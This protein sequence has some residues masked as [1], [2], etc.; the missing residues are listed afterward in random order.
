M[1][2]LSVG[3]LIF[4]SAIAGLG[5]LGLATGHFAGVWQPV[6]A[7]LPA[8]E[9]FA[10]A[11]GVLMLALGAGLFFRRSASFAAPILTVYLLIWFVA[12]RGPIA[13]AAPLVPMNWS[14]FGETG[15]MIVGGLVLTARL[16]TG[17]A[18]FLPRFATG[19]AGIRTAAVAF[20][21]AAFLMSL[22]NLPYPRANADFP[23]AWIPHW[24]GWGFLVGG[25]YV[26]TGLSILSGI[27]ARLS[28]YATAVMMSLLTLACWVSFVAQAPADRLNWTG[29][30]ISS[31][32]SG[33][34]WMVAE[35]YGGRAWFEVSRTGPGRA[36]TAAPRDA[37]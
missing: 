30:L 2:I 14:G 24:Y 27:C 31:A 12:L 10:Y 23:P 9:V 5:I 28:T 26:A 20:A 8:R 34:A 22:A 16:S 15:T 37:I 29:L 17:N 3:Q 36:D 7:R 32:L 4:A 19:T 18:R 6:P 33:A 25:A 1:R 35:S 13:A 11:N 21:F